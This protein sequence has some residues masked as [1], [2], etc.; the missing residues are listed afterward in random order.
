[1]PSRMEVM[2]TYGTV[3]IK[4]APLDDRIVRCTLTGTTMLTSSRYQSWTWKYVGYSHNTRDAIEDTYDAL[5]S[6]MWYNVTEVLRK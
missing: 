6:V 4:R 2:E 3:D 5:E 1:M